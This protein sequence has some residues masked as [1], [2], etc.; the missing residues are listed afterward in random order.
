MADQKED[1]KGEEKEELHEAAG[2]GSKTTLDEVEGAVGGKDTKS[3]F[4]K[5]EDE[6][7]D[8]D[9]DDEDDGYEG[10]DKEGLVDMLQNFLMTKLHLGGRDDEPPVLESVTVDAIVEY[11]KSD[12]CK[13]IIT[14]AGAGISTSAG[15]PD[16]RSP[17]SG[18]Y[19]NLASSNLPYPE[20]IFHINFFKSNPKPFFAL[21]KELYPGTFDPT[22]C[23]LFIK[24][25]HDKGLLLRHYTQNI[26]TLEYVAGVPVEK[27]VEAHGTFRTSHCL[28]CQKSYDQDWMKDQIFADKIPTCTDCND[29]VKPDIIFFGESLPSEFFAHMQDDF[30]K[31]DLLIIMGTSLTVQPFASLID[32]VPARCP[33]LLINREKVGSADPMTALLHGLFGGGGLLL[34]SPNNKRD[35]AMLGDCDPSVLQLIDKL[36]W[37]ED[38]EKLQPASKGAKKED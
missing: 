24:L 27:M 8:D 26:D 14:M 36:G 5:G 25:L 22:P 4:H 1:V 12:K 20:A 3:S 30:P 18:L 16:F 6:Y 34:D 11:M 35:V 7:D 38:F 15:I 10:E 19:A 37:K 23:H 33:R 32:N 21:A 2:A 28:S 17:E 13:N 9:D 29:L 31:C